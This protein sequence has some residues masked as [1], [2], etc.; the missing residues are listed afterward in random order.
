MSGPQKPLNGRKRRTPGSTHKGP[1]WIVDFG[2]SGHHRWET[3][4]IF[5]G[6]WDSHGQSWRYK[7]ESGRLEPQS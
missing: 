1:F 6:K 2:V 3:Q 7:A 4:P 5:P